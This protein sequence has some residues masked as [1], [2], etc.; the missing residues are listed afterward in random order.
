MA[1]YYGVSKKDDVN[2][3]FFTHVTPNAETHGRLYYG[4]TGP[5]KTKAQVVAAAPT[6]ARM[7]T[8][9]SKFSGARSYDRRRERGRQ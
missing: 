7:A 3:I 4:V 9:Y 5:Y 8:R 2:E 6:P 1:W